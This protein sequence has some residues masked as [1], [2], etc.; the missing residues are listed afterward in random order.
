MP[1]SSQL[2]SLPLDP[3]LP[4]HLME[5]VVN[6]LLFFFVLGYPT[7]FVLDPMNVVLSPPSINASMKKFGVSITIF[8]ICNPCTLTLSSPLEHRQ[9]NNPSLQS[10]A[11]VP[12]LRGEGSPLPRN[13]KVKDHQLSRMK[14]DLRLGEKLL[15]P[16]RETQRGFLELLIQNLVRLSVSHPLGQAFETTSSKPGKDT[17]RFS[18][19]KDRGRLGPPSS[20]SSRGQ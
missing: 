10:R 7:M 14:L 13:V 2:K 5:V 12:L 11:E 9:A 4:H 20:A 6:D 15:T 1:S 16:L 8:Q 19:L 3:L 18:N 17:Q